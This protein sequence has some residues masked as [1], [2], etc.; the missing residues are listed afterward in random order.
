MAPTPFPPEI[1][2][3]QSKG[4]GEP[5]TG[6]QVGEISVLETKGSEIEDKV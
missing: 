6:L 3:P 1:P 2:L 4:C 5:V